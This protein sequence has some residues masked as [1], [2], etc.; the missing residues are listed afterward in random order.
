MEVYGRHYRESEQ[1]VA[2]LVGPLV[3]H[4]WDFWDS[5]FEPLTGESLVGHAYGGALHVWTL[6]KKK[7]QQ[8]TRAR[9]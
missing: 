9:Q 6:E 7:P 8:Q 1:Q 5:Q 3:P 2:F 4:Y